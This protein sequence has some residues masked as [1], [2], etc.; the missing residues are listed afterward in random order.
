MIEKTLRSR[1]ATFCDKD[2]RAEC[3]RIVCND[4]RFRYL[5]AGGFNALCNYLLGLGLYWIFKE[6]MGIVGIGIVMNIA[7]ITFSFV[8]YKFFVF[9]TKS[10][11][12]RE[13]LRCY[14]V[15]GL[16]AVVGIGLLSFFVGYLN[17]Q[18]WIANGLAILVTP[19]ISYVG[20][21]R[22]SFVHQQ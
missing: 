21:S 4:R 10:N 2:Q 3:L 19:I 13:Y 9:K 5:A 18:F 12:I 20:H 16:S 17:V 22:F 1:Y 7:N 15:Y 14:I 8:V 11:W 6:T